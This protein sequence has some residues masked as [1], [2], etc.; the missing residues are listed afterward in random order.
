MAKPTNGGVTMG[1]ILIK[2]MEI[3]EKRNK[4]IINVLDRL[5]NSTEEKT[6][7]DDYLS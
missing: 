4:I 3:Q 2:L 6:K 1:D 7:E 5:T